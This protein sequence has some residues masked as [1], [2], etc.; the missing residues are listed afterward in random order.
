MRRRCCAS[1]WKTWSRE[2]TVKAWHVRQTHQRVPCVCKGS[3]GCMAKHLYV[4]TWDQSVLHYSN[5]TMSKGK[6]CF[7]SPC[8]HFNSKCLKK[9]KN[10]HF[11]DPVGVSI[12]TFESH[13]LESDSLG[14]LETTKD[15]IESVS[16]TFVP[17]IINASL[18]FSLWSFQS[19]FYHPLTSQVFSPQFSVS[20]FMSCLLS[21]V[22][23]TFVSSVSF[24]YLVYLVLS[25]WFGWSCMYE[26]I[27]QFSLSFSNFYFFLFLQTFFKSLD[28]FLPFLC[29]YRLDCPRVQHHINK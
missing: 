5:K 6:V 8:L 7:W 10:Q 18:L 15:Q 23:Y 13:F 11:A 3:K 2:P 4:M 16:Q 25:F 14:D 19:I 20:Y 27:S 26:S 9:S 29:L 21:D 1:A 17:S 12:F 22:F 24:L 28:F